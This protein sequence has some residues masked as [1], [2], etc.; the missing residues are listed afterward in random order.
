MVATQE[1]YLVII[2]LFL[3]ILGVTGPNHHPRKSIKSF[4]A[5]VANVLLVIV[6]AAFGP[7][8][9]RYLRSHSSDVAHEMFLW[10]SVVLLSAC[11]IGIR[12]YALGER[13][14]SWKASSTS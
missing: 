4:G 9:F 3:Y 6:I 5:G 10:L 1:L 2:G 11:L 13:I 8:F 14:R 7:G 12:Y